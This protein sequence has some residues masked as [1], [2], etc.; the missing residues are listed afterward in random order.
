MTFPK[1]PRLPLMLLLAM[2]SFAMTGLIRAANPNMSDFSGIWRL[3]DQQSDSPSDIAARLRA[4]RKREQPVQLP[5]S[6]ASTGAPSTSQTSGQHG[7]HVG[8]HGMGG[9]TGG[10]GMSGGHGHGG[11]RGHAKAPTSDNGA[12]PPDAPPPLLENDSLLNVQQDAKGIRVVL[13]DKD[14]LD[15]RLDGFARQ[16]LNGGAMVSSQMTAAGM[17]ITMQFDGDVRLQQDWAQSPDGHHLIVTETWTTPAV[18]QPI[19]F[20]RSY[21]R[22]DI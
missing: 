6:A 21:D 19:V 9:G 8:G 13:G 4:E 2:S 1:S 10:G 3:N 20:K 5:A 15:S 14:Q 7:G 12:A 16:S 11:G 22:L 18:Q 17:Q